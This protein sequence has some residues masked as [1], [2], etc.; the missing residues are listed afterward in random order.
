MTTIEQQ[1]VHHGKNAFRDRFGRRATW[2]KWTVIDLL[3]SKCTR[4]LSYARYGQYLLL[5]RFAPRQSLRFLMDAHRYHPTHYLTSVFIKRQLLAN[6]DSL[7]SIPR[8]DD[9]AMTAR[10]SIVLKKPSADCGRIE[11]GVLLITF[12]ES[13]PYFNMHID[14]AEILKFFYVVLEPSWAGYCNPNILF[15][16]KYAAH[17]IVVQATE[18]QDHAFLRSLR[19]NLIPVDFGASDWVDHR[20]F[21]PLPGTKKEFDAVYVCTYK[22]I[23]R[24]HVLFKAI[25]A[26]A[27]PS[28]RLA[29]ACVSWGGKRAEMEQ[30]IDHY[31][32]RRNVTLLE[33]CPPGRVNEL[34]NRSKVNVLLSVK[35]GSNRSIFEGLFAGV[36]CIV[37]KNNIGVN[38][39]YIHA[40]TGELIDEERLPA[41]L[42]SFRERWQQYDPREWA[43]ENISPLE[44][45]KK[46]SL[47]LQ[48]VAR[49]R[50]EP[51]TRDLVPKVNAPEVAY[52][53]PEHQ[54]QMPN[55]AAVLSLFAKNNVRGLDDEEI[56]RLVKNPGPPQSKQAV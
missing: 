11:K 43:I 52:F 5:K 35:E 38:K 13:F 56:L 9:L 34:L 20:I 15:W 10:R 50:N 41:T 33:N 22:P 30:L 48:N 28:Y 37:L 18:Q 24:H 25:R 6:I 19:S 51:W 21:H 31:R 16:M 53:F 32:I 49:E 26:I 47:V 36:P 44:T 14:C 17:P 2:L 7:V 3:R 4:P 40:R 46:L 8:E 45:T 39:K 27:D 54:E 42:L 29:L 1:Q 55:S 12:T 23:K